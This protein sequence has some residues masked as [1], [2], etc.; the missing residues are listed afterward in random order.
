MHTQ[1]SKPISAA[2]ANRS[3]LVTATLLVSD[4]SPPGTLRT[5][6]GEVGKTRDR[7]P[8]AWTSNIALFADETIVKSCFLGPYKPALRQHAATSLELGHL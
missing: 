3:F 7:R 2:V 5:G 4:T 1:A 8:E 6:N